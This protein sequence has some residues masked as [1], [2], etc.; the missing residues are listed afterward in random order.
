MNFADQHRDKITGVLHGFDRLI[1]KG[2]L[3]SFFP[4]KGIYYYLSQIGVRL[5]GYNNFMKNQQY[6]FR[7]HIKQLAIDEEVAIH[8]VNKSKQSKDEIAKRD[9][10]K[11]PN[12][13]GLISI[14]SCME[15]SPSF[16]LRGNKALKELEVIKENRQHLHYYLFF[17]DAEFGWMHFKIQSWYP[18]TIQIYVNGKEHLKRCLE[19]QNIAFRTYEN[20][21]SWVEDIEKAQQLADNLVNKKWDRFFNVLA[22]KINPILPKIESVFERGYK[23]YTH[24]NEYATDVLFKKRDVLKDLYSGLVQHAT[25]FKG[26]EDIYTFFGRNLHHLSTKEVSGSTK[27]FDQGFRV[28]HYLDKNSV[29]MYDKNSVLR[30]ETTITNTRAFK[31]YKDVVRKNIPTKAW[32]PMG[33]A[34]SNLYRCAQIAKSC[35]L[36]YL[37]SLSHIKEQKKWD[38]KIEQV[39]QP[40]RLINK[41][42]NS[43]KYSAFNL[44]S[45]E[46]CLILEAISHGKFDIQPFYNKML[47]Q[48]LLKKNLFKIDAD[49]PFTIK[50]ISGKITR[51]LAKLRAHKLILKINKSFKYKLTKLG[52]SIC[53]KILKFKKIE[54]A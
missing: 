37:N 42:N 54:L 45:K 36:R 53:Y 20:S 26:G 48:V 25:Y 13:K 10:Q 27:R 15:T 5:T 52:Q 46:T 7:T 19:K 24:Q 31:I 6:L 29:K 2:Y 9:F 30:I 41:N 40:T 34:V 4:E 38:R 18:F 44:L 14:I 39:S 47:R 35:N 50:K 32:V 51:L 43:V 8:Y 49:D 28:K 1:F 23:W 12:K 3:N 17:N 21:I 33:K 16:S 11:M 22:N